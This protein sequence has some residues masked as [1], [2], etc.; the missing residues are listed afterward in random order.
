[1]SIGQKEISFRQIMK[2]KSKRFIKNNQSLYRFFIGFLLFL[3]PIPGFAMAFLAPLLG[4][5]FVN[6]NSIYEFIIVVLSL[7]IL[8]WINVQ[9]YFI[10]WTS[11][12]L[13]YLYHFMGKRESYVKHYIAL[14]KTSILFHFLVL[15]AFTRIEVDSRGLAYV[16]SSYI[17]LLAVFTIEY[18]RNIEHSTSFISHMRNSV[19]KLIK[20]RHDNSFA[21]GSINSTSI[22]NRLII[23]LKLISLFM[24]A[25]GWLRLLLYFGMLYLIVLLAASGRDAFH[26]FLI[27][28]VLLAIS[29]FFSFQLRTV[30]YK[31]MQRQE[32][33]FRSVDKQAFDRIKRTYA[34]CIQILFLLPVVVFIVL[35]LTNTYS[36]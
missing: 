6:A 27:G 35:F 17:I 34:V 12:E 11:S 9:Y 23:K 5:L 26:I 21:E 7:A 13:K 36:T 19:N 24:Q 14:L 1:M 30:I 33:F 31:N 16:V 8:G 2:R 22:A 15:A 28:F 4:Y 20:E 18:R 10:Y 32:S 25:G 29:L 3:G